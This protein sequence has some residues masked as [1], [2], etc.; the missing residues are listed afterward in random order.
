[1]VVGL[2]WECEA[3][4]KQS[5]RLRG[6]TDQARRPPHRRRMPVPAAMSVGISAAVC[7][8]MFLWELERGMS[9]EAARTVAVNMLVAGE[10]VYLFNSRYIS[11]P[12]LTW[13]G[14]FGNRFVLLAIAL[15]A[16]VQPSFTYAGFMQACFG[17]GAIGIAEWTRIIV[18]AVAIFAAVDA[19]KAVMRYKL[20]QGLSGRSRR[21]S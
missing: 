9:V 10:M 13:R 18:C 5:S 19:E 15:L 21:G 8:G 14:M 12:A 1:M 6:A 11:A 2:A 20:G 4:C 3:Q 7:F 16:P 17:T